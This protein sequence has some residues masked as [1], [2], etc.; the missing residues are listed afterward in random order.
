MTRKLDQSNG[1]LVAPIFSLA[2]DSEGFIWIGTAGGLVRYDGSQ[3]RPWAKNVIT[4]DISFI[5]VGPTGQLIAGEFDGT[6][7]N[8]LADG[9]EILPGPEGKPFKGVLDAIFDG[10]GRLWVRIRGEGLFFRDGENLWHSF[11]ASSFAGERVTRVRPGPYHSLFIFTERAV[12]HR[13][14][15]GTQQRI[16][17]IAHPQNAIVHPDG[18]IFV[19]AWPDR[20]EVIQLRDGKATTRVS[21]MARPI[22]LVLRGRAIWASFDRFLV[23]IRSEEPAEVIGADDG[24]PSGG[25]LLVDQEGSLWLGTFSSLIQYPEP[26]TIIW[27]QKDGLPSNHTRWLAR[28]QEGIWV[29]YFGG[30][31]RIAPDRGVW[32]ARGETTA[33][34]RAP[35]LDRQDGVWANSPD[36]LMRRP[37]GGAFQKRTALKVSEL[38]ACSKSTGG[39]IWM[40]TTGGPVRL[41][42]DDRRAPQFFTLPHGDDGQPEGAVYV[43]EDREQRVWSSTTGGRI[44]EAAVSVLEANPNGWSCQLIQN[45][46]DI[47]DIVEVPSGELWA[48]TNRA[49]LWRFHAGRWEQHPASPVLPSQSFFSLVP[50]PAG[51]LWLLGHGV[52][53]RVLEQLDSKD[54]W[55]VVERISAWQGLPT[56]G[57]GSLVEEPDG[58]LWIATSDGVVQLPAAARRAEA[59]PPRVKFVEFVVNGRRAN[60]KETGE[61]SNGSQVE[62][63][64]AAL[65]YRD[66]GRLQYQYR[67]RPEAPWVNV[68]ESAPVLRFVD[69]RAGDYRA[70]VRASLDGQHWSMA[71]AHL[72]FQVLNPWYLRSW[73]VILFGLAGAFGLYLAHRTRVAVLMRLE[74]QRAEI[75]MDLHDEMGSGLG[76]IGILS[77]LVAGDQLER[78]HQLQVA[79]K[80]ADTAGELGTALTEIVWTLG[81]AATTLESLAYHLAE[82]GGRLFPGDLP[83]FVTEFPATWSPVE[84]SLAVRRNL[85]LIAT[86][87]LHNASRHAQARR[88]VLGIAPAAARNRWV[89]WISDDGRGLAAQESTNGRAGMGLENMCRRAKDIRAELLLETNGGGTRVSIVFE[90][91]ADKV[92]PD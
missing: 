34:S 36:G 20:G 75:A 80:I 8:V 28:S 77:E 78:P 57:G 32:R 72:S 83:T 22:D 4:R 52:S 40:A 71:P 84:L 31:A 42:E 43:F 90:P 58:Q 56:S 39:A 45:Y 7:Y 92:R 37:I 68:K 41:Y 30:L 21:L 81:T 62:L 23:A 2:Q 49:G 24:L 10:Q 16:L 82:R 88:V 53:M 12:W 70:E 66:P 85:L 9:V 17:E 33:Q 64:F 15:D 74:N 89:L 51:G 67:L 27:T 44:C 25:P 76:S 79:R 69:L 55:Q 87:A 35:C 1:P 48:A 26:D 61:L 14:A 47:F 59:Q 11:D 29:T 60:G 38:H 13:Y 3:V 86:E 6:L 63:R 19:L 46:T 73:A 18:S 91:A 65:S 5:L 54:G 50:S